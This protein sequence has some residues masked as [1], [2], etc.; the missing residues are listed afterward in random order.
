[1][2]IL[3]ISHAEGERR[4]TERSIEPTRDDAITQGRFIL[5]SFPSAR[6]FRVEEPQSVEHCPEPI[7]IYSETAWRQP[8]L[9]TSL[10][11]GRSIST[12]M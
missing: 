2:F 6:R 11:N 4:W 3:I 7:T 1:M 8:T 9:K 12:C 5:D 10:G